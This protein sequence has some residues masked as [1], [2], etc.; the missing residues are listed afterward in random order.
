MQQFAQICEGV[1]ALD[2]K[3]VRRSFDRAS[4]RSPLHLMSAWAADQRLVLGQLAVGDKSNKIV[5]VPKLLEL[6]SLKGRI[7]TADA[8]N[9]QRQIAR[10]AGRRLRA[11]AEGQPAGVAR[12]RTPLPR[13]SPDPDDQRLRNRCR[14]W[15]HRDTHGKP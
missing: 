6:L 14:T 2:G 9:C 10:Q 7:V 1:M 5:A 3:T 15:P 11:G 13:R 12:R 4:A 8:L